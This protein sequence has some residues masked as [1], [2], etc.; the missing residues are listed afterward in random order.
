[1]LWILIGLVVAVV[2]WA[3][4]DGHVFFLPLLLLLPL[5]GGLLRRRDRTSR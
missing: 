5:G 1:M 2:V 4:S 3:V